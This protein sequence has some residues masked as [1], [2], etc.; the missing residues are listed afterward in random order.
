MKKITMK[1]LLLI[2]LLLVASPALADFSKTDWAFR[3]S[4]ELSGGQPSGYVSFDIPSDA[5]QH[6]NPN[7]SDL[8]IISGGIE[9]PF[10]LGAEKETNSLSNV[11]AKVFNLSS[12]K[13]QSTSF[14]ADIGKAGSFH[15]RITIETSSE[16]FKRDVK[17]EGSNDQEEW[18]TLTQ[19]GQIFD[20]TYREN[21][22]INSK[23]LSIEYPQATWRYLRVTIF[24]RG[25]TPL[26]ISGASIQSRL[27]NSAK[28][29]SYTPAIEQDKN[30]SESATDLILDIGMSG[31]PHSRGEIALPLPT[32]GESAASFSRAIVVSESSD[33]LSWRVLG[34]GYIFS[35]A[36]PEF[37]GN[38]L[39]FSYPE[40]R[41]RYIKVS[42]LNRDDQPIEVSGITLFGIVR[43]VLFKF[44]AGKNYFVYMGNPKAKAGEYD[45]ATVSQYLSAE[46]IG[47]VTLEAPKENPDFMPT[48]PPLS[49]RSPYL[50]P[51]FLVLVVIILGAV[52]MK[53]FIRK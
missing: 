45:L 25:E 14:V 41:K 43:K 52:L 51:G 32:E 3:S 44:E 47:S 6:L 1:K 19:S 30:S 50:L 36:T 37:T 4:V 27:K 17:I 46:K 48:L 22:Y 49:E 18:G 28:E 38:N 10:V 7:L 8:R 21:G 12:V 16:N 33:K 13:G 34:H 9:I 42:V 29:I 23:W 2:M 15:S 24:D 20:Y 11:S 40:S 5:F 31:T 39:A 35:I 53:L 26:K